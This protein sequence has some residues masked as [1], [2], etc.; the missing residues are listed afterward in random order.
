MGSPECRDKRSLL[1]TTIF[2][3]KTHF[4][5]LNSLWIQ[6]VEDPQHVSVFSKVFDFIALC[7]ILHVCMTVA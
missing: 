2:F 5:K 6:L 1:H 7:I 3:I 4:Q